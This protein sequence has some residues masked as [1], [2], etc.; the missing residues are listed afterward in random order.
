MNYDPTGHFTILA[1]L[2]GVGLSLAFEVVEDALDGNG[3]DHDWKDYLGAG[4]SGLLGSMGGGLLVQAGLGVAGG[5]IDAWLSGDLE[6][7]GWEQ[8]LL[9][10]GVSTLIGFVSIAASDFISN[11]IQINKLTNNAHSNKALMKSLGIK[12]TF[13]K[14]GRSINA[15]TN[16]LKNNQ[17]TSKTIA[18]SLSSGISSNTTSLL[19]GL[20]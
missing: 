4:I 20:F 7:N 16:A 8:T 6:Q 14:N 13:N 18:N 11:K 9:S 19:F 12:H 1:L 2:I 17:W 15:F 5:M 3:M 10:I